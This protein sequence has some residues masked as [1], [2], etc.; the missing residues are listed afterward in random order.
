VPDYV[1]ND[2]SWADTGT[3]LVYVAAEPDVNAAGIHPGLASLTARRLDTGAVSWSTRLPDYGD[4][5]VARSAGGNLIVIEA[6]AAGPPAALAADPAS[7]RVRAKT[8]IASLAVTTPLRVT[9]G[10]TLLEMT[11]A[12][13]PTASGPSASSAPSAGGAAG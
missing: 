6:G 2:M 13:C 1:A 11:S 8:A 5:Q 4:A 10:D 9:G 12:P 3:D 7:G